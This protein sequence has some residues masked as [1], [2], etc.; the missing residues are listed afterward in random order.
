MG[1][2]RLAKRNGNI[3]QLSECSTSKTRP[4]LRRRPALASLSSDS[5]A[6]AGS[7]DQPAPSHPSCRLE[8]VYPSLNPTGLLAATRSPTF[9]SD[10]NRLWPTHGLTK[11]D[12]LPDDTD[13][14]TQDGQPEEGVDD[15]HT[16]PLAEFTK[17]EG[18]PGRRR[19]A[20]ADLTRSPMSVANQKGVLF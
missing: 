6:A 18:G 16:D 15:G 10:A 20:R 8:Q 17:W 19:F 1:C 11:A 12:L 7:T 4:Q 9:S 13:T 3:Q 14:D 2:P 5:F